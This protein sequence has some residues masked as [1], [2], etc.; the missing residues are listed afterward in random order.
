M[1]EFLNGSV[2]RCEFCDRP[3]VGINRCPHAMNPH[4]PYPD[5]QP[6]EVKGNNP[7]QNHSHRRRSIQ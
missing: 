4:Y 5:A 3:D 6:R 1:T 7:Y 2:H